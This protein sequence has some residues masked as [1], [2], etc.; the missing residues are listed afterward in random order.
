MQIVLFLNTQILYTE[1]LQMIIFIILQ[2]YIRLLLVHTSALIL[3][4]NPK[5]GI[6]GMT[7]TGVLV[8]V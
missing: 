5:F 2:K 6:N 7:L 4:Q 3:L 8:M 1:H